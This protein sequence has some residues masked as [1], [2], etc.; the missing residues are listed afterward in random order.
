MTVRVVAKRVDSGPA[1]LADSKEGPCFR[2]GA[3]CYISEPTL[4]D[5]DGAAYELVCYPCYSAKEER[6]G[7]PVVAM[8]ET[9]KATME[10]LRKKASN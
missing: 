2:C 4:A 10:H 8:P 6:A 9:H 7:V 5:L 1:H 3:K